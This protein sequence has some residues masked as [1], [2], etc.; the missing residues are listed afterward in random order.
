MNPSALNTCPTTG[1]SLVSLFLIFKLGFL[2][3]V[4][5]CLYGHAGNTFVGRLEPF[6]FL[7][8]VFTVAISYLMSSLLLSYMRLLSFT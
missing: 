1:V 5:Q 7:S 2:L 8:N 6:S 3:A 4:W